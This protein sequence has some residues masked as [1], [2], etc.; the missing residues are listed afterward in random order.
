MQH[1]ATSDATACAD[2]L[3]D[4]TRRVRHV[5]SRRL[6]SLECLEVAMA[7]AAS[8]CPP[9]M[10]VP[11]FLNAHDSELV[12]QNSDSVALKKHEW[13][14]L[15]LCLAGCNARPETVAVCERPEFVTAANELKAAL[16]CSLSEAHAAS[17]WRKPIT[18]L[19]CYVCLHTDS[20]E[21]HMFTCLG[22]FV[23]ADRNRMEEVQYRVDEQEG[24]EPLLLARAISSVS[25]LICN[26]AGI[27]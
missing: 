25:E 22:S 6:P 18:Q 2:V 3:A 27:R 12:H 13:D 26:P 14:T 9:D 16:H 10:L 1:A 17:R 21:H 23:G 20:A 19:L 11:I 8:V 5:V 7:C 24:A 15:L 4:V